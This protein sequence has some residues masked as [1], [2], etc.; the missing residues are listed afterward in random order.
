[1]ELNRKAIISI[2]LVIGTF[3]CIPMLG[4]I[5][6]DP[7]SIRTW[8]SVMVGISLNAP[9][10][11]YL[12]RAI[13]K[14]EVADTQTVTTESSPYRF[15]LP[16]VAIGTLLGNVSWYV[17]GGTGR[18]MLTIIMSGLMAGTMYLFAYIAWRYMPK[19]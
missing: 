7:R 19:E 4:F 17:L 10:Y 9:L 11:I 2:S 16:T 3:S 6:Q 15:L 1:M 13:N 8:I 18:D 5:I 14:K 12:L